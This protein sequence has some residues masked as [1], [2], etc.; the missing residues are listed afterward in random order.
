MPGS[1]FPPG[2]GTACPTSPGAALTAWYPL[3]L[4]PGR[5]CC[6]CVCCMLFSERN[7]Y[8]ATSRNPFE[9][10]VAPLA[11]LLVLLSLVQLAFSQA[12][13]LAGVPS[14]AVR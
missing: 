4:F 5:V 1:L 13:V 14:C 7:N 6:V 10:M 8:R 3:F 12:S 11:K 9:M 2:L